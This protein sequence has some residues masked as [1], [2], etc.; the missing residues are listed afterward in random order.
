MKK[1]KYLKLIEHGRCTNFWP[2][3]SCS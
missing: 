1:E 2:D 3:H